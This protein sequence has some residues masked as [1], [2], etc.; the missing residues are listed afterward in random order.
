MD[1]TKGNG[2]IDPTRAAVARALRARR[3]FCGM[4]QAQL[5]AASGLSKSALERLEL[6]RRDMD[7]PQ[8]IA[9]S[10]ALGIAP[11]EFVKHI[12]LAL[13]QIERERN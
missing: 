11:Q 7:I 9:L 5:I 12:A 3:A 6:G 8:L 10:S 13:E 1:A 4:T 2:Y